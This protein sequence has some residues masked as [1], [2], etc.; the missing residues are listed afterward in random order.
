MSVPIL[1]TKLYIPPPRPKVIRRPHLIERLNEGLH[2]KLTLIS[3]PAGF[4]K[5]TLVSEWIANCERPAAWLS[6]EEGDSH[7]TRFLAYLV[8]ALQTIE[9]TIGDGVLSVLQSPQPPPIDSILTSLLNEIAT[10][11]DRFILILDDYHLIDDQP[12]DHALSFLLKHLPPSMHLVIATREDP[13]LPLSQL[14]ARS[15]LTELRVTDLRF[16]AAEA[17]KFLNQVMGLNLAAADITALDSRT[18]GWIAG[19]QLAALSMQGRDDIS[20][21]I[22]T[23]AGDNRY[24]VD[25]LVD[26][27]LERQPEH[28]RSF[29]LQTSI[30]DRLC[31][32][33]CDAVTGQAHSN[34]LLEDLERGNLFVVPLD[35]KR[36][37]F[38][39]HH[40]FADVLYTHLMQE[41]PDSLPNLHR[42][43]SQWYEHNVFMADAV[44]HAIAAQ[45]VERAAGLAELE[46]STM[47]RSRQTVAWL[48][49]VTA[50]PDDLIRNRPVLSVGYS[51][52]LL[53]NGELEA[54]E[55]RL[56]DAEW[57][58]ENPSS[59]MVVVDEAEFQSLPATIASARAYLALT[60]GDMP[61]MMQY[62]RQAID[63]LSSQDHIRRGIPA[64]LLGL[65]YWAAGDLAAADQSLAES[66]SSFQKAGNI[67]LAI[68]GTFVLADIRMTQGHLHAALNT[69]RQSFQLAQGQNELVLRGT[70]DLHTGLSEL[71]CERNDLEAATQNLLSSKALGEHSGLPHWQFRWCIAK[72]RLMAAQGDLD[73]ALDLLDAAELHYVRG[74][75]PDVRPIAALKTRIWILQGRL[76]DARRWVRERGLSIDDPLSYVGEFEHVTL[77]RLLIAQYQQ[78]DDD[79]AMDAAMGLLERLRQAAE[80][81]GRMGSLIEILILQALA[82]HAQNDIDSALLALQHA[83]TIAAPEGCIRIFVD[84]GVP[85]AELLSAASSHGIT[86]DY[87]NQL[88]AAFESEPNSNAG[89]SP[90]FRAPAAQPLIKPL[91]DRELEVLHLVAQGLSNREISERLYLAL[92]T[93]KGHNRRIYGKLQVQRRTE[94]VARARELGLI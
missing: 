27:V 14:R 19:L 49:W 40:L 53:D 55:A 84:E 41:Q 25:Y 66:M 56:R 89:D 28:V 8:S 74:P 33:L 10:L 73:A 21:F 31:G 78:E 12:I 51:W 87:T 63:R 72:A 83:L 54:A 52:A 16:T 71:H 46:W 38:R 26:E 2:R 94:A 17:A 50:L 86:P 9:P 59:E 36:H 32:S 62:A 7:P 91:S 18:E 90:H 76:A 3:A 92:D 61:A 20:G 39:Y 77:A 65:A 93:V 47:D 15:Q 58:L 45:D 82:Y 11:P 34:V 57:W 67:L 43:A 88:L 23:F 4:G 44:R 60:H 37:W 69:Y 64:G 30:L 22:K 5:T 70:A 48:A 68:T 85:M 29:L 6:L 79:N 75:V 80:A 81:G 13:Q 35:D 1:A 24:I 42:H